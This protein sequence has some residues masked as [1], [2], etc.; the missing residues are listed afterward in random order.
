[1]AWLVDFVGYSMRN[2]PSVRTS[3]EVLHTLQVRGCKGGM[4]SWRFHRRAG[5]FTGGAPCPPPNPEP[6][7]QRPTPPRPR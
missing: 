4:E 7:P 3:V 5:A 2:A 6:R 1:M